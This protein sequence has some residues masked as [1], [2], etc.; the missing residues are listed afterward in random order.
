MSRAMIVDSQPEEDNV[1]DAGE[2]SADEEFVVKAKS[3]AI[4]QNTPPICLTN[5]AMTCDRFGVSDRCAAT[6]VSAT[7]QDVGL[8]S[9]EN[10]TMVVDRSKVRRERSKV[11]CRLQM[12]CSSQLC[13]LYFDGRK[14]KTRQQ[15]KKGTKFYSKTVSEEHICLVQEPG[16]VYMGHLTP[17]SSEAKSTANGIFEF[18]KKHSIETDHLVAV[19]C[20][21]TN[22]NT[23]VNRGVIRLLEEHFQ[24]PL[25]WFVCLLHTNELPLRHIIQKLD[26]GTTGPKAFTGPIGRLLSNCEELPVVDFEPIV[27]QTCPDLTSVDLSNDQRYL[28]DMC[29]A[30]SSG[31]CSADLALRKPGPVVHSRWLTTA[32]RLLRLYVATERP[33]SNL[34]TL[35]T[36][37]IKVYGPVWFHIKVHSSCTEGCK[38][39]WKMIEFSRYLQPTLRSIVDEVIQRNAYFCHSENLLLGMLTDEREHIRELAYRR[40]LAAR[41]ENIILS[42]VRRFRVPTINFAAKDYIDLVDWYKMDRYDPPLLKN[43]TDIELANFVEKKDSEK[44]MLIRKLP[45]HTQATERCIRL[46]TEASAAVCGETARDGFIRTRIQSRAAMKTFNTKA[47]YRLS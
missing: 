39:I 13:G 4:H 47:E 33:S 2:S 42:E 43:F 1:D 46:V 19:G 16:S 17:Q 41:R 22:V 14:D 25:Q 9:E 3:T 30:V 5:V 37:V 28:Y 21:G 29:Q 24:R 38:N 23:G 40:I 27:F 26:G 15:I 12:K 7:L 10:M 32:N 45:C 11:R 8:V 35:V 18:L 31:K 34:I 36:Y 44:S 6:L 20:D